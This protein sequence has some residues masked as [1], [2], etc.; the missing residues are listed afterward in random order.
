MSWQQ[1]GFT[2]LEVMIAVAILAITL[3]VIYG[4]QSQSL[5][6][7]VEAKFNTRAAFLLQQKLAE[8]ESGSIELRNDEGDYGD[9]Y[10]GFRWKVEVD[11][12]LFDLRDFVVD[13][14]RPLK[15]VILEVSW[16]NSPYVHTV[17]YYLQ[18]KIE[19]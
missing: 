5:S 3:T 8:L 13:P 12:V 4:S 11:E 6:L 17:D 1:A 2:L 18:E 9:E 19:L 14:E 7:A 15:R 10:P 16:E